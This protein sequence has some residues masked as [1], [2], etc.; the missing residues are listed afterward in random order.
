MLTHIVIWKYR[1]DVAQ[2]KRDEHLAALRALPAQI[3]EIIGF[4][5]GYDVLKL[6]RSY[7][8]GLTSTFQDE[9]ALDVYT[10]HPAHQIV[11]SLGKEISE[12]VASVDFL[13]EPE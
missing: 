3:P 11:V 1:A 9:A 7:H 4:N 13:D 10:A 2:E 8:T 12:H 5:V 6:P